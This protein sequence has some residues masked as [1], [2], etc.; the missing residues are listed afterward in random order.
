MSNFNIYDDE[1]GTFYKIKLL[2][3]N[4]IVIPNYRTTHFEKVVE[5]HLSNKNNRYYYYKFID[6]EL[7]YM[8]NEFRSNKMIK[9]IYYIIKNIEKLNDGKI[10]KYMII[11]QLE[12]EVLCDYLKK[13]NIL[14]RIN[15]EFSEPRTNVRCFSYD[16]YKEK[17]IVNIETY[18]NYSRL[19]YEKNKII[20]LYKLYICVYKGF[21][22]LSDKKNL[23]QNSDIKKDIERSKF[24]IYL[25]SN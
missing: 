2:Y 1:F 4:T 21:E 5:Y 16:E 22:N 25:Y 18:F 24:K 17:T 13:N 23:Y 6:N 19:N 14:Y 12:L 15:I 8:S 10:K 20:K 11:S 3:K 9:N 7:V